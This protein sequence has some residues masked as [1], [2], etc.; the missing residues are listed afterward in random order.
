MTAKI[1]RN[2]ENDYTREAAETRREF[3]KEQTSAELNHVGDIFVRS[4]SFAR[5]YRKFY[6]RGAS[7]DWSCRTAFGQRRICERRIFCAAGDD[8]RNSCRFV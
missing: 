8:R 5:K 2:K 1:P 6:R 7:S 3:A 4:V